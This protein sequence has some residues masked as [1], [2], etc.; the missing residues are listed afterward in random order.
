MNELDYQLRTLNELLNE[1]DHNRDARQKQ[2]INHNTLNDPSVNSQ[3]KSSTWKQPELENGAMKPNRTEDEVEDE[4]L[5]LMAIQGAHSLITMWQEKLKHSR[6]HS[7]ESAH[8]VKPLHKKHNLSPEGRQ[9]IIDA[10]K[11]RWAEFRRQQPSRKKKPKSN[12]SSLA[13]A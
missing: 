7:R 12:P 3:S 5:F 13:V 11:R 4:L 1:L 10:T 6:E 9:A 8:E 2:N